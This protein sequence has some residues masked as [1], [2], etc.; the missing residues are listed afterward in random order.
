M[1]TG[2]EV[3]SMLL[4]DGG[5]VIAGDDFD[6]IQFIE[7]EPITKSQFDAGFAK[8]DKAKADQEAAKQSAKLAAQAKLTALGLTVA[9]L[10]ALGL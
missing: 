3:L 7:A 10:E 4:P 2:S 5:W 8:V 6:N 9:D 1:A